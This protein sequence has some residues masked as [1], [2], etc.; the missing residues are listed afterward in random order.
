MIKET[1]HVNAYFP[2]FIPK[3]FFEREAA[4]VEGFAKECAVVTH[5]RLVADGNGGLKPASP[6]EEVLIVRPT[7]ETIIG[8]SFSR[9]VQS[10]RDLP[11]RINQWANVV[12]WEMR[13]RLFLRTTEF[14]WQEGHTAH[15]SPEEARAEAMRELEVYRVFAEEYMAMPV[16]CGRKPES[17]RFPG[18]VETLAIEAMMQDGKALQAGTS[19]FLGQNFAKAC[20]IQFTD[21]DGK[22]AHAWTTSWGSTTRLIGGL[23]MVHSDDD[24]LVLPPKLAPQQIVILPILHN[25][26]EAQPILDYCESLRSR[27]CAKTFHGQPLRALLDTRERRGGEKSWEWIK[28]GVP[29]RVEAGIRELQ[30]GHVL[31]VRRDNSQKISLPIGEFVEKAESLLADMQGALFQQALEFRAQRSRRIGTYAEFEEFFRSGGGFAETFFSFDRTVEEKIRA[32]G[33]IPRCVP[34]ATESQTGPCFVYLD[35]PGQ[36]VV[37]AK[38]Y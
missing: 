3:S 33:I 16:L 26:E 27:L 30:S 10:Y 29:I 20:N 25:T 11:L 18:A 34:L 37:W 32:M 28:K 35:R 4:H 36:L 22:L 5:S 14:L 21:P 24:G 31:V 19:H 13:T 2:L 8:E 9:W 38:S 23:V 6:L 12:R 7:S 1:G 15:A 17:E